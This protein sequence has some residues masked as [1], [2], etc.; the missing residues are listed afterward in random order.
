[1][2]STSSSSGCRSGFAAIG[3]SYPATADFFVRDGSRLPCFKATLG[4]LQTLPD[5]GLT[6]EGIQF[7]A[8]G[9]VRVSCY[10]SDPTP[11]CLH[12]PLPFQQCCEA[13]RP[14]S[15]RASLA[16]RRRHRITRPPLPIAA[17]LNAR[18]ARGDGVV[19]GPADRL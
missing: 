10:E 11:P 9:I 3:P 4:L 13:R 16:D 6:E 18:W 8:D 14:A 19:A 12:R 2:R 5:L 17:S 15:L 1:M 7:I